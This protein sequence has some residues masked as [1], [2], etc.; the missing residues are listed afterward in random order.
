M[1]T[2]TSTALAV[3][4]IPPMSASVGPASSWLAP[5]SPSPPSPPAANGHVDDPDAPECLPDVNSPAYS[6][7][8]SSSSSTCL[9][10]PARAPSPS[11]SS[12]LPKLGTIRCYWTVL[13]PA[14]DFFFLDPILESHMGEWANKLHGTNLLDWVHP[15]ERGRLAEDLLPKDDCIAGIEGAGVFGSVTR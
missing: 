13:S 8:V 4:S 1:S 5:P 12:E 10:P 11:T 14:L 7:P 9:P 3:H 6:P 15:E 2:E